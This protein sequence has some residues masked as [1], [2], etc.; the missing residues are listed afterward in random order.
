MKVYTHT[1]NLSISN[2]VVTIGVFDG[3]HRGHQQLI[4]LVKAK[5]SEL[6]GES[7]VV[8]FWP[9]PKIVLGSGNKELLLLTTLEEKKYLLEEWGIDHLIVLTF[10]K[11]FAKLSGSD[12]IKSTIVDQIGV[13]YLIIGDDHRFGRDRDGGKETLGEIANEAGFQFANIQSFKENNSRIS[14]SLVRQALKE[15]KLEEVHS[16]LGFPYFMFGNVVEGNQ[17]G[18]KIG[19]PT[20]NIECCSG[21]KQ[22]PDEGVYVVMVD[23]DGREFGGMLNIGTRPTVDSA[24]VKSIE[25][26]IF[27]IEQNLYGKK[28]KVSFLHRL[29]NEMK[30]NNT[31]DLRLQLIKDKK[32]SLEVLERI[33][34]QK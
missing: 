17:F 22:I 34:Y 33:D 15:G 12:F 25:V 21:N 5:A 2:P 29:R 27:D 16:L 31:D 30:F 10:T 24:M 9:H 32:R 4:K 28:L 13:K 7:V 14:S 26:H 11:E 20:A 23:I 1:D 6:K 3:L 19:F 18:R 8:T